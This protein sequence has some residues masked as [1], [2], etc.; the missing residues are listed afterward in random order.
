MES[1]W[2]IQTVPGAHTASYPMSTWLLLGVKQPGHGTDHTPPSST[3]IKE[4]VQLY[5]YS[6]SGLRGLLKGKLYLY[7]QTAKT[8]KCELILNVN[9]KLG[10]VCIA[11]GAGRQVL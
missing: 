11:M 7:L 3:E 10:T 4:R 2:G 9:P 1:W 8:L 6:T 5:L